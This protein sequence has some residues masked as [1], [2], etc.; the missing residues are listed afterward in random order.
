VFFWTAVCAFSYF[1]AFM[2]TLTIS[3]FPYYSFKDRFMAYTL[4]SAF[5]GIY[6]LVSFPVFYRLDEKVGQQQLSKEATAAA[7]VVPH[8]MFQTI[9]EAMGTSMIVLLLLDFG[10][11]YCGIGLNIGGDGYYEYNPAAVN[12]G[13]P[14]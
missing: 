12:G 14:V 4:G 5:Y 11:L 2:E 7:V 8:T 3:S 1:T 10:R 13:R 9:M 6:F